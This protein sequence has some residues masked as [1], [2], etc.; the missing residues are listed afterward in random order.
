MADLLDRQ[1]KPIQLRKLYE[2]KA[3]QVYDDWCFVSNLSESEETITFTYSGGNTRTLPLSEAPRFTRN[4]SL[5]DEQ[6]QENFG[7]IRLRTT[8]LVEKVAE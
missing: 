7:S 4:L 3:C 2:D 6:C 5:L 8:G 1:G